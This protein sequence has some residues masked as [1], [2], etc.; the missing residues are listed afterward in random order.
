ME[1]NLLDKDTVVSIDQWPGIIEAYRVKKTV[2]SEDA[3]TEDELYQVKLLAIKDVFLVPGSRITPYK[4][5]KPLPA[6]IRLIQALPAPLTPKIPSQ[7]YHFHQNVP[8]LLVQHR[9]DDEEPPENPFLQ[10]TAAYAVALQNA[11]RLALTWGFVHPQIQESDSADWDRRTDMDFT[12][13]WWGAELLYVGEMALLIP[14]RAHLAQHPITAVYVQ[15][16]EGDEERAVVLQIKYLEARSTPKEP[17][18]SRALAIG[19]LYELA[20][21]LSDTPP[22][23]VSTMPKQTAPLGMMWKRMLPPELEVCVD[24]KLLAGR[25]YDDVGALPSAEDGQG[26]VTAA[27][28]LQG[29]THGKYGPGT[30]P[31]SYH[32]TRGQMCRAAKKES[33]LDLEQYW[34]VQLELA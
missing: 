21:L 25:Y 16:N 12:G 31:T 20:P 4:G 30:A 18:Q 6:V 22:D 8:Y 32:N 1:P 17:L 2:L 9:E 11:A 19:I 14:S 33:I 7:L 34:G 28:A 5:F 3:I 26:L 10:A 29:L 15:H 27:T 23:P 13:I 24:I